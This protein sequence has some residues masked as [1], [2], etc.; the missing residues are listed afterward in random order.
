M[1]TLS[2][3]K[4]KKPLLKRLIALILLVLVSLYFF[5]LKEVHYTIHAPQFSQSANQ[6]KQAFKIALLTD[7]HGCYYGENQH[8][9]VDK[10]KANHP[11][12]IL[13]GGDIYDDDVA[14]THTDILLSQLSAI[15]PTY[16]VDG[17]HEWWLP[18]GQRLDTLKRISSYGITPIMGKQVPI[19]NTNIVL[20]G[21]SDPDSG[22]FDSELKLLGSQAKAES[23][24]VLLSHRPERIDEYK[25][26]PFD[27]VLSGHAHGGQW[28]IPYL[29]NGLIAPNQGLFPKYAGGEYAFEGIFN[30]TN[31]NGTNAKQAKTTHLIVSRGLARESTKVPRFFNH[32]ELVFIDVSK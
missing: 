7:L 12:V 30:N 14:F 29:M 31:A 25:Q 10:L 3:Q 2:W 32:P 4:L 24:N 20:F 13:L 23:V 22:T 16:Y 18:S 5:I 6:Q 9:I 17:N 21:L 26:Y 1:M 11:D 19:A 27:L 8:T 28:R 15:A